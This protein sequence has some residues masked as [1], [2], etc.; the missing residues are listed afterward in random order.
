MHNF[1]GL[2]ME[3]WARRRLI[4]SK[5][6]ILIQYPTIGDWHVVN[7]PH[8]SRRDFFIY[9]S[10]AKLHDADFNFLDACMQ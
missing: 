10:R 7:F 6:Q 8:E 3:F 4:D 1:R 5:S 9:A 2:R